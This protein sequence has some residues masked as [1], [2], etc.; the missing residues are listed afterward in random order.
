MNRTHFIAIVVLALGLF[1]GFWIAK[2]AMAP[3]VAKRDTPKTQPTGVID[4]PSIREQNLG[5]RER[6]EKRNLLE[7]LITING[8]RLVRFKSEEA[9]RSALSRLGDSGAKLLGRMDRFRALR[10]RTTDLDRLR[11]WLG[12]DGEDFANYLVSLPLIPDRNAQFGGGAPFGRTAL[13]FLG[14]TGDHSSWGEGVKIAIVDT[15]VQPHIALN[16]DH[17]TTINLEGVPEVSEVHGHGTAVASII[18]GNHDS[19]TGVA[20]SAE[21]LSIPV[22]DELGNSNSFLLAEGITVAAENGAQV[23]NVSMGSYGDSIIVQEAVAFAIEQGA[24]I[25]ASVGNEGFNQAAFPAGNEGVVSVGTIDATGTHV[26]F[27]NTSDTLSIT[28]PGYEVTAAWPGD[29]AIAFT[30][31]SASAP[32]VSATIAAIISQSEVPLTGQQAWAIAQDYTNE[33]GA[34]GFDTFYGEGIL[35]TGR[36]M[37]RNTPGI[38]DLAVAQ[39]SYDF[40]QNLLQVT[41]ENRGTEV[42]SNSSLAIGADGG[43]YPFLVPTLQPNERLVFELPVQSPEL[44]ND[45]LL[46]VT[47]QTVIGGNVTDA[48]PSNNQ[49]TDLISAPSATSDGP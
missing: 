25:I 16:G 18:S 14:I 23:I 10:L 21:L 1:A 49:R 44:N 45:G 48:L 2:D 19:L 47:S 32:F 36:I 42:I 46:H 38:S 26:S 11:D 41:V 6:H 4:D 37:Q 3:A 9:Y 30:G 29:Q 39:P 31:T 8:E 33:A 7:E 20:P 24:I 5:K 35:H 15:G 12:E 34:P 43:N 28:A 13:E 22:T 27:S 40:T 17:I